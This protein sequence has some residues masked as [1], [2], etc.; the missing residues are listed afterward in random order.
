MCRR[1]MLDMRLAMTKVC[2]LTCSSALAVT[3]LD[4]LLC[5]CVDCRYKNK[6]EKREEE[7]AEYKEHRVKCYR[8]ATTVSLR[9]SSSPRPSC[10]ISFTKHVNDI[11]QICGSQ[12][13]WITW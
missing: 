4:S 12:R 2:S 1:S 9:A 3:L 13:I 7:R 10:Y 11:I 6:S 8:T 5:G